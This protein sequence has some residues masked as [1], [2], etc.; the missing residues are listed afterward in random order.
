MVR[1][2]HERVVLHAHVAGRSHSRATDDRGEVM[3]GDGLTGGVEQ[4]P[5]HSWSMRVRDPR[6][7]TGHGGAE[8]D[9][10]TLRAAEPTGA[11]CRWCRR[12][13]ALLEERHRGRR[14]GDAGEL[15][16]GGQHHP[17]DGLRGFVLRR[18]HEMTTVDGRG[19]LPAET[20]VVQLVA[21]HGQADVLAVDVVSQVVQLVRGMGRR[22]A[23]RRDR[24]QHE[25]L[26]LGRREG[27]VQLIQL[28]LQERVLG[29]GPRHHRG[30]HDVG[31]VY[32]RVEVEGLAAG[33]LREDGEVLGQECLGGGSVRRLG[34]PLLLETGVTL[35]LGLLN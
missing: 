24:L 22:H 21:G 29:R 28:G 33:G 7:E 26:G 31:A 13:G 27:T 1:H 5:L 2:V 4:G 25:L 35:A 12:E 18:E 23:R 6:G 14:R 17:V 3:D 34:V 10:R 19:V 9:A 20:R 16:V 32:V 8:H 15:V 30:V 11:A